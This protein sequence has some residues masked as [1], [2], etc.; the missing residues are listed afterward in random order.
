MLGFVH[1]LLLQHNARSWTS[2]GRT[3]HRTTK[4]R[5]ACFPLDNKK[6]RNIHPHV[7]PF[8]QA[9]PR[10]YIQDVIGMSGAINA[11]RPTRRFCKP[12][13]LDLTLLQQQ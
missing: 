3:L 1:A 5:K 4:T 6:L 11:L 7:K 2:K 12:L 13:S 10:L 8:I 9:D